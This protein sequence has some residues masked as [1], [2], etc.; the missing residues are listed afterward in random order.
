LKTKNGKKYLVLV[1]RSRDAARNADMY[2]GFWVYVE[3][4]E[5]AATTAAREANEELLVVSRDFQ[6][7]RNFFLSRSFSPKK[8]KLVSVKIMELWGKEKGKK[9]KE[10]IKTVRNPKKMGLYDISQSNGK[11]RLW[12]LEYKTDFNL[13]EVILL[14][15]E[16]RKENPAKGLL[17]R[18]ISA[19]EFERFKKLYRKKKAIV[20]DYSFQ[21]AKR[22]KKGVIRNRKKIAPALL[23]VLDEFLL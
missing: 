23:S 11:L 15:G 18:E 9:I 16:T 19:F 13:D 1:R 7:V 10:K 21:G 17:D 2:S 4:G 3:K 22:I 14:D 6:K 20:A 12:L 8:L 5:S